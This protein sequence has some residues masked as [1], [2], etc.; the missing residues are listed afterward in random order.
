VT[1]TGHATQLAEDDAR[2]EWSLRIGARHPNLREF[3]KSPS[4]AV[5]RVDVCR[6]FYVARF[7]EVTQ[8]VP[9]PTG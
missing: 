9:G 3:L 7:Q 8:W 5:F 1:V 2:R 4:T 6:Y